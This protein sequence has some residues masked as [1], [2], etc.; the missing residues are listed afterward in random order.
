MIRTRKRKYG[1]EKTHEK[2][3]KRKE[4]IYDT[5]GERKRKWRTVI[6]CNSLLVLERQTLK[7]LKVEEKT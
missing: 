3:Y 7:T 1:K 2:Q 6:K 5:H 4:T